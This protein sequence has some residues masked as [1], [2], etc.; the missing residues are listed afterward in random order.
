[1][2]EVLTNPAPGDPGGLVGAALIV[3][4]A[5]GH[6]AVRGAEQV[7]GTEAVDLV[8]Q[9]LDL[10]LVLDERVGEVAAAGIRADG[11]VHELPPARRDRLRQ[12]ATSV[13]PTI[14]GCARP[15]SSGRASS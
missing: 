8:D 12:G 15:P 11:R 1:R 10:A 3:E 9:P 7:V 6:G 14:P 4:D 2:E 13:V 5:H